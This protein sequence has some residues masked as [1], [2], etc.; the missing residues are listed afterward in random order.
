MGDGM[1]SGVILGMETERACGILL[2]KRRGAM[3]AALAFLAGHAD[4]PALFSDAGIHF[5]EW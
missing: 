4:F 5:T 3:L 1:E 2:H